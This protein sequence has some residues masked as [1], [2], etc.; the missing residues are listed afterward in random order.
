MLNGIFLA[1]G[2][3]EVQV[4]FNE[5][6]QPAQGF[7]AASVISLKQVLFNTAPWN[8]HNQLYKSKKDP[9]PNG[10]P[11]NIKGP[12]LHLPKSTKGPPLSL[13][14]EDF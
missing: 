6:Y 4:Y 7:S 5:L 10:C 8:V 2:L 13:R 14:V 3:L 9:D 12:N 11:L 1:N